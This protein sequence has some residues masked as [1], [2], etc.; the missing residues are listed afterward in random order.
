MSHGEDYFSRTLGHVL[1]RWGLR[2]GPIS[3]T[4]AQRCA[5]L[6]VFFLV[7]LGSANDAT[8]QPLRT[9]LA[10]A[11]T[12]SAPEQQPSTLQVRKL[13][14]E[15]RKLEAEI[16]SIRAVDERTTWWTTVLTAIGTMVGAV[17]GGIFTFVITRI[18][19]RFNEL[20]KDLETKRSER[21]EA[22]REQDARLSGEKLRQER[23]HAQELHNLRLF[24]DLGHV[25]HRA[26]LAAAAVLLHRLRKL[27]NPSE[28]D[29]KPNP[30]EIAEAP[31]I[32]KVLIAVLKRGD[33]S[34]EQ[35]GAEEVVAD[36]ASRTSEGALRKYIADELV[37]TLGVRFAPRGAALEQAL[38]QRPVEFGDSRLG[39]GREFQKC[40]LTDAYWAFVD[41]R[42][43]DFFGSDLTKISLRGAALQEAVFYE[44]ILFDAT[45]RDAD[46]RK[47]NF[48]GADLRQADLRNANLR[49]ANLQGANLGGTNLLGADLEGA[50]INTDAIRRFRATQWPEKFTETAQVEVKDDVYRPAS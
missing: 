32:K 16:A 10:Q 39:E 17:V 7:T 15:V 26:R 19:Q 18:G 3:L 45:L 2:Q 42:R 40:D 27:E 13:D 49:G 29:E 6:A 12:A 22:R 14:A 8:G 46:L 30:R 20:Q 47:A 41:A 9:T 11:A 28:Q 43:L 36:V 1:P 38:E 31:L 23:E 21:D 50:V 48:M 35:S 4:H 5:V 24:Q 44:A 33:P 34:E 37:E 25:S